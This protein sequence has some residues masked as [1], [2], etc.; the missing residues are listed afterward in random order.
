MTFERAVRLVHLRGELF[1][2]VKGGAMLSVPLSEAA[3][4]SRLPGTLDIATVNAPELTTVSGPAEE[5]KRFAAALAADGIEATRIPIDV[6]AHSRLL[7]PILA[8]FRDFLATCELKPPRIPIVSNL[9]GT[10]LTDAEATSPDYWVRHLRE[11]VR[12]ADGIAT[13]ARDPGLV[14]IEAGPGRALATLAKCHPA[15]TAN[16][17]INTL[18]HADD[19]EDDS[20][21]VLAALGRAWALGLPIA[22]DRLAGAPGGRRIHLP[23]Y[24]FQHASYFLA[25][26]GPAAASGE[27]AELRRLPDIAD[28]GSEPAWKLALPDTGAD[29]H[30]APRSFLLFLD[31][32]GAGE[33]LA[34]RLAGAGHRVTT[35]VAGDSF[36]SLGDAA[37]SLCPEHGLEGYQSLLRALA[38]RGPLPVHIV[39]L[40]L[41]TGEETIRPGSSFYHRNQERGFY[42]LLHLAQALA[43]AEPAGPVQISVITNGMQR[44][45]SE[46]LP[47]PEKATVLGPARVMPQE[48]PHVQVRTIDVPMAS[49][50]AQGKPR[51]RSAG[52]SRLL[53]RMRALSEGGSAASVANLI[54]DDLF[55][56]PGS[57]T[58]AY[59][60]ERRWVQHY[61]PLPLG[62]SPQAQ[63]PALCENGVYLIT[64]GFGDLALA[65]AE[66]ITRRCRA[67]IVLVGRSALPERKSHPD[68]LETYGERDRTGRAIGAI[69]RMEQRGSEVLALVADITDPEAVARAIGEARARFGRITGVLHAA[70]IV[71]DELMQLKQVSDI[72]DV[73]APKVLGTQVLAA[74]LG[75]DGAEF[76]ALFSSTSTATAPAGQVDYVAANAYLNAFAQSRAGTPGPRY[77]AVGWGVWREIGIAARAVNPDAGT[78]GAATVEPA[79]QPLFDRRVH[80]ANGRRWVELRASPERHW[81]LDEHRLSSGEAIWP[82]TGY[83]ELFAEAARAFGLSLPMEISDVAFLRPLAVGDGEK[84]TLRV[85]VEA[86]GGALK[87]ALES[88]PEGADKDGWVRHAEASAGRS[89]PAG[90]ARVDIAAGIAG[91]PR[92]RHASGGGALAAPQAV[93]LRF[94]PRWQTLR[95][96]HL[97]ETSALARLELPEAYSGDIGDGLLIHPALMDM[98]TGFAMELIK[99][100][101][102]AAGLWAPMSYGRLRVRHALPR[103]FWSL[104]RLSD[105][106]DLGPG[107]ATFDVCLA[108]SN[109]RVLAEVDGFTVRQLGAGTSLAA[110]AR[111]PASGAGA[112]ERPQPRRADLSPALARLA[113]QVAEGI[114]AGEGLEALLRALASGRPEVIVSSLSL[115]ALRRATAPEAARKT[116]TTRLA[117]P[118]LDSE[119]V[120]PRTPTEEQLAGFWR[121]LLGIDRVGVNDSFFDLGGH[122]LLAVRLFRMVKRELAVE[123]PISTL[124]EAPTIAQCASLIDALKAETGESATAAESPAPARPSSQRH[125]HLVLMDRGRYPARTPLFICAGMF[126]NVL[127][128]RHLA[129]QIGLDRPVY[130]LQARGLYGNEAPHETIKEMAAANLAEVRQVQPYGPYLISGFSGGGLVA[131]EMARQLQDAGGEAAIVI[132]LDTP[133]PEAAGLSIADRVAM[134]LQDIRRQ[135]TAFFGNWLEGKLRYRRDQR[136]KAERAEATG[137]GQFHNERIVAAFYRALGHYRGQRYGG[138]VLLLRP[139][140]K[141]AY[142]LS[143][144]RRLNA[145]RGPVRADNGWSPWAPNLRVI[146]V[147]GDHDSMVL[148]PAV[149]VLASRMRAALDEAEVIVPVTADAAE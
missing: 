68:Y 42:S 51:A 28:W 119:L 27:D 38:A 101:D 115:A 89:G 94:G 48:M 80:D 95:E 32:T 21:H 87:L 20:L 9:T 82:G 114:G 91:S 100:Y 14:L 74:A 13:L 106:N 111:Q 71:R 138:P 86:E 31:D 75:R 84:C 10:W 139:P 112:R 133:F 24:A 53:P 50:G 33:A 25:A 16:R 63:A 72:E 143:G 77:L 23:G 26:Q 110:T 107:F 64:G 124:F 128:L 148:E 83:L 58:V 145:D 3:L 123:L 120:A 8:R 52:L 62:S 22:R 96:I 97:G 126:G 146:E 135:G 125:S 118:E 132:M 2:E 105:G 127:N 131:L 122:S 65:L 109:G 59:R 129:M 5:V 46:P 81:L 37:F 113:A 98:A 49:E 93:H 36:A 76:V 17:V 19:A 92:A 54:W 130:G 61:R 73:L 40:W 18:P 4:R 11:T 99:G 90:A 30:L 1:D 121:E 70:G 85:L 15:I 149:R 108:D 56:A 134:R 47:Y 137:A 140:L 117:R 147:G 79:R 69:Q 57:E 43:E 34:Q 39:H 35:V 102:P 141:A 142:E 41:L 12:F 7:E 103:S 44:V 144:G 88:R 66:E 60:N 67:K 116:A 29:A 104:A 55:A 6:A 45:A 136:E 78:A